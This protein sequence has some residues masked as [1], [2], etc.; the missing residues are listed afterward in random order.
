MLDGVAVMKKF[1]RL[2]ASDPTV[3]RV[4]LM[5]DSSD[6]KACLSWISYHVPLKINSFL[7]F[8]VLLKT[9]TQYCW[10]SILLPSHLKIKTHTIKIWVHWINLSWQVIEAGLQQIQGK[11]I[12]NS[13]SLKEGEKDFLEKARKVRRYGAALVVMA[14][15]EEGNIILPV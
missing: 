13:L 3:A 7:A 14:F 1:L 4:P 12:V 6:W 2:I 8:L 15:D 10:W 11:G 9:L 5:I